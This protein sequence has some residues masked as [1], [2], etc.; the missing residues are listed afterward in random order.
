LC[1]VALDKRSQESF[2][3][4]AFHLGFFLQSCLCEAQAQRHVSLWS[5]TLKMSLMD[6]TEEHTNLDLVVCNQKNICCDFLTNTFKLFFVWSFSFCN[7]MDIYFL[8]YDCGVQG[9]WIRLSAVGVF[10]SL[11]S[12]SLVTQKSKNITCNN[13][14]YSE[15]VFCN[16]SWVHTKNAEIKPTVT[17]NHDYESQDLVDRNTLC[18]IAVWKGMMQ[19]LQD[20]WCCHSPG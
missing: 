17:S 4:R 3:L 15:R 12:L 7:L 13:N 18:C 10:L 9:F 16:I 14:A 5:Q 19:L 1:R 20:L 6:F 11:N 2:A 8:S